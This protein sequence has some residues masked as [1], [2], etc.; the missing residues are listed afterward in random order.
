MNFKE[1][2]TGDSGGGLLLLPSI[3]I[4]WQGDIRTGKLGYQLVVLR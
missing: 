4:V 1:L 3:F 2:S